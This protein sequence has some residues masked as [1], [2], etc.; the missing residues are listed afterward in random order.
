MNMVQNGIDWIW[1][2]L[3]FHV[4]NI[5]NG[6][7]Y[8]G[9]VLNPNDYQKRDWAWLIRKIEKRLHLW[10]DKWLSRGGRLILV[11]YVLEVVHVY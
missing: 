9:F 6:C 3:V 7:R 1:T 2:Q 4:V 10:C 11:K 8:L 5:E